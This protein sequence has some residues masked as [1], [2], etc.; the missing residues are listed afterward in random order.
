MHPFH[1]LNFIYQNPT[2]W[3]SLARLGALS[4]GCDVGLEPGRLWDTQ[5]ASRL[6]IGCAARQ[7]GLSSSASVEM[8]FAIAWQTLGSWTLPPMQR[9]LLGQKAENQICGGQL[10][11]HGSVCFGVR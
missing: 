5:H 4:C 9:A 7:A 8:A 1:L 3:F 11:H 10:R 2:R 6:R